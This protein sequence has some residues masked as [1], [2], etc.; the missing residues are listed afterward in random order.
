MFFSAICFA[1]DKLVVIVHPNNALH[2]I[3][4]G[5]L[6]AMY[7]GEEIYWPDGTR[8][9]LVNQV[10]GNKA[11]KIF[12]EKILRA[13]PS[14][15]FYIRGTMAPIRAVVQKSEQAVK[16]FVSNMPQAI[17]YVSADAVDES[18]KVLYIAGEKVIP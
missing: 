14:T 5:K 8:I 12:Y 16:L 15:K 1:E 17:G 7:K 13:S 11:R 18:V 6:A 4:K 2:A 10:I 9:V 3:S